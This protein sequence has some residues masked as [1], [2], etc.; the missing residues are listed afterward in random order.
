MARERALA[1][2]AALTETGPLPVSNELLAQTEYRGPPWDLSLLEGIELPESDG[3]P[4]ASDLH[5]RQMNLLIEVVG[6]LMVAR[7][8]TNFW[9]GGDIF[10]YYTPEQARFVASHTPP[11]ERAFVGPD[12]VF[13]DGVTPGPRRSWQVWNEHNRYP[14]V[15]AELLSPSTARIDNTVKKWR[16]DR[17]FRTPEYYLYEPDSEVFTAYHLVGGK[18]RKARRG[19]DERVYSKQL[20][21]W[22]GLWQGT[23][24]TYSARWLRIYQ[25]E[26]AS[27]PIP[28]GHERAEDERQRAEDERRRAEDERQRAEDERQ[29]AERAE[30]EL[31]RLRALL[32]ADTR[33]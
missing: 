14:D 6:A 10:I 22:F 33:K 4:M 23:F 32:N 2:L 24:Q 18:Y 15:I 21:A 30:A 17:I 12:F 3:V 1:E 19:A 27:D 28:T 16:Y 13:I 20:D 31:A 7:G 29:R 26:H 5:V 25:T 11:E 8:R 9:V